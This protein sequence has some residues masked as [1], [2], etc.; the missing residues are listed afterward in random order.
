MRSSEKVKV[1]EWVWATWIKDKKFSIL[2]CHTNNGMPELANFCITNGIE[3]VHVKKNK[4]AEQLKQLENQN[5]LT[6][7]DGIQELMSTFNAV[8][9]ICVIDQAFT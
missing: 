1:G 3:G 2:N 9:N 5:Y 8:V 7:H 6:Y 4:L